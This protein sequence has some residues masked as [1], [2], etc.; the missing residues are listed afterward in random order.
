MRKFLVCLHF[1]SL[2]FLSEWRTCICWEMEIE[3]IPALQS[4]CSMLLKMEWDIS[5]LYL[6]ANLMRWS[7]SL[8]SIQMKT[9]DGTTNL[10]KSASVCNTLWGVAAPTMAMLT[11][12][13]L[14]AH[15]TV[16]AMR[17][18]TS[19]HP[20]N[21]VTVRG[22]P[23]V[24]L[25]HTSSPTLQ[26]CICIHP[27]HLCT[28]IK[29]YTHSRRLLGPMVRRLSR[30]RLTD[31]CRLPTSPSA[32][33]STAS[34]GLR[35]HWDRFAWCYSTLCHHMGSHIWEAWYW[36]AWYCIPLYIIVDWPS[37]GSL[38]CSL[39]IPLG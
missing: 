14:A 22:H 31:S 6:N 9:G 20:F 27:S 38:E 19:N 39:W 11:S 13:T 36:E 21:A 2:Y 30:S 4:L 18:A 37:Q 32:R 23:S 29:D 10:Q 16:I 34:E 12:D 33:T 17:S 28:I 1:V 15:C 7:T 8:T 3:D 35:T 26:L 5:N 24:S 25:L